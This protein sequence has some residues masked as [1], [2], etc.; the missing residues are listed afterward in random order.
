MKYLFFPL[1]WV[2]SVIY[3]VPCSMD[4]D[5]LMELISPILI[6]M[7]EKQFASVESSDNLSKFSVVDLDQMEIKV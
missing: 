7:T 1:K 3:I 6:G 2:C 5:E 4:C